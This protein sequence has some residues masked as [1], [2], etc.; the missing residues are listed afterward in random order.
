MVGYW[1]DI[2]SKK[3]VAKFKASQEQKKKNRQQYYERIAQ[4]DTEIR[5]LVSAISAGEIFPH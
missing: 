2:V 4:V 3:A 5:R 1:T